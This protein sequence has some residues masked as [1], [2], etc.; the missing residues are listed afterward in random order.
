MG[1]PAGRRLRPARRLILPG[2]SAPGPTTIHLVRH[3]AHGLLPHTL[4]G[5]MPGVPLSAEGQAQA[6]SLA[7]RFAGQ[8]IA[9]VVASPVQRAQETAVPVAA[10][11]G[12]AVRTEPGFEEIDFGRWTG[13][14]FAALAADPD[15][16]RWNRMRSLACCPGGETMHAAQSRALRAVHELR[17]EHGAAVLVV[18]SHADVLKAVLAAALGL[19]LDL[20]HRL[21]LDPASVSTL[22]V[23]D[24]DMRVDGVN[25]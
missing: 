14:R 11:L 1:L 2:S 10:A 12:L 17:A 18:V 20:L 6:A 15:W 8:P 22:L 13:C 16:A 4:A 23:F 21:T 7:A 25:R 5:R 9:A 24:A 3:A 19:S